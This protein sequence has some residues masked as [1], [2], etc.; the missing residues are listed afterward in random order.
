MKKVSLSL[1]V[2]L[3]VTGSA[4]AQQTD[5]QKPIYQKVEADAPQAVLDAVERNNKGFEFK[6]EEKAVISKLVESK[7]SYVADVRGRSLNN[8]SHTLK[9]TLYNADGSVIS[10]R[11]ELLNH[12]LPKLVLRTI[13]KEYNGWQ[14]VRTR[15]VI[16]EEGD[17]RKVYYTAV[18]KNGKSKERIM[19]NESGQI[20]K[21][22]RELKEEAQQTPKVIVLK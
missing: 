14:L 10:S 7:E 9:R 18:L 17:S 12:A 11:E 15:S 19:L 1:I 3:M 13:G 22:K 4:L 16:E 5:G 21:N 8:K 20:V 2:I 6:S